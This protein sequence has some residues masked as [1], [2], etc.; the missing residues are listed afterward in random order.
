MNTST[1]YVKV[2]AVLLPTNLPAGRPIP[3]MMVPFTWQ[4]SLELNAKLCTALRQC[5][6]DK[7]GIRSIEERRSALQ[8]A[9]K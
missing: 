4:V 3:G 7:T 2:P 5:N 6:L 8:S 1:V 9:D